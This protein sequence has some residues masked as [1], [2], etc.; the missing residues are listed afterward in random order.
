MRPALLLLLLGSFATSAL[1]A[2]I[3][4]Q[5]FQRGYAYA[6]PSYPPVNGNL[7]RCWPRRNRLRSA[8]SP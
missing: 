6:E 4:D 2:E 5:T 1:A 7:A 3:H 8:P